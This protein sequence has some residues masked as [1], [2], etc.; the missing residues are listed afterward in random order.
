MQNLGK[1][2][3]VSHPFG[4]NIPWQTNNI[5]IYKQMFDFDSNGMNVFLKSI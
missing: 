2:I 1:L 3:K 4:Q 5:N